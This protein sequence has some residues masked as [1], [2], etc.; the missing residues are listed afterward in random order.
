MLDI[1]RHCYNVRQ[2]IYVLSVVFFNPD[3][4]QSH[5]NY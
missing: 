3:K 2:C 5:L 1:V 4:K